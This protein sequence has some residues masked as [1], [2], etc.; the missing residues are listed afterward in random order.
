MQ[1]YL[2][3]EYRW[4]NGMNLSHVQIFI[5]VFE[6][7]K[8]VKAQA[9]VHAKVNKSAQKWTTTSKKLPPLIDNNDIKVENSQVMWRWN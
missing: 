2:P 5:K 9:T 1:R 6:V 3:Y 4:I 8:I 7:Q